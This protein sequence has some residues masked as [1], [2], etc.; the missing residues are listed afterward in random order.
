M[1]HPEPLGR[2]FAF[3]PRKVLAGRFYTKEELEMVYKKY[4][5]WYGEIWVVMA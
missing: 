3:T 2:Y 5:R 4:R 1:T